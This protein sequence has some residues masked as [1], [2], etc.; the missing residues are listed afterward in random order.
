M[1]IRPIVAWFAFSPPPRILFFLEGF[2]FPY[3]KYITVL[4]KLFI[5]MNI[6]LFVL[7]FKVVLAAPAGI[8]SSTELLR[9]Y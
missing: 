4:R 8:F 7:I 2:A 3:N 1:D 5:D 9:I 6:Y